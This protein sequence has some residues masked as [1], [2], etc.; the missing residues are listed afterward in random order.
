[1]KFKLNTKV[2]NVKKEGSTVKVDVEA[3]KGGNKETVSFQNN[4]TTYNLKIT[5]NNNIGYYGWC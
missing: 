4:L 1:M 3:A 5:E 2:L